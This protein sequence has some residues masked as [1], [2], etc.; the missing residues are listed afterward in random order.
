MFNPFARRLDLPATKEHRRKDYLEQRKKNRLRYDEALA[1]LKLAAEACRDSIILS[2]QN[3]V[4]AYFRLGEVLTRA[5]DV[6]AQTVDL[7]VDSSRWKEFENDIFKKSPRTLRLCYRIYN[8][9]EFIWQLAPY[10]NLREAS[11]AI[12]EARKRSSVVATLTSGRKQLSIVVEQDLDLDIPGT[13]VTLKLKDGA[14]ASR[15]GEGIRGP[16]ADCWSMK[17]RKFLDAVDDCLAQCLGDT[18]Y[19]AAMKDLISATGSLRNRKP[20]TAS[21]TLSRL[22]SALTEYARATDEPEWLRVLN[23]GGKSDTSADTHSVAAL[24]AGP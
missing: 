1:E 3:S 18:E 21:K 13:T 15:V 5:K 6:I 11:K 9:A 20:D 16:E 8:G 23:G 4:L 10:R 19:T 7:N 12:S 24:A 17:S 2:E 14:A 22:A